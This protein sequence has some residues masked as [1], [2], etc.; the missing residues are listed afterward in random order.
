[1][2]HLFC[3][4][5]EERAKRRERKE[6]SVLKRYQEGKYLNMGFL[7]SLKL[8]GASSRL[9][10][11]RKNKYLHKKSGELFPFSSLRLL[12]LHQQSLSVLSKGK[13]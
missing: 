7:L 5:L 4:L 6:F 8:F 10:K 9:K 1:M 2:E 3:I 13:L 12:L 11:L